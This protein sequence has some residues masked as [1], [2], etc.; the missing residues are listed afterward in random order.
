MEERQKVKIKSFLKHPLFVGIVCVLFTAYI[1][2]NLTIMQIDYQ[3]AL[4]EQ[5]TLKFEKT[6]TEYSVNKSQDYVFSGILI[7][8]PTNRRIDIEQVSYRASAGFL[9]V[10]N[11]TIKQ[12]SAQTL[13]TFQQSVQTQQSEFKPYMSLEA[14]ETKRMDGYFYLVMPKISGKYSLQFCVKTYTNKEFCMPQYLT[15][16]VN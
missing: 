5:L 3:K 1:T 2:Y 15:L 10:S 12:Q 11:E 13:S 9:E 14:G 16:D 6:I 8:N 4:E 7:T